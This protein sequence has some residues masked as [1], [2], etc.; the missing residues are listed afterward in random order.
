MPQ[1]PTRKRLRPVVPYA[2][3]VDAKSGPNTKNPSSPGP[4][5]AVLFLVFIVLATMGWFLIQNLSRASKDQDCMMAGR[6]NC[7]PIDT[8]ALRK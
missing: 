3:E 2:G 7:A 8:G 1:E 6:K 5:P 4:R